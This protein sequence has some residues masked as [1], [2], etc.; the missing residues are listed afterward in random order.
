MQ[1]A[2]EGINSNPQGIKDRIPANFDLQFTISEASLQII[3]D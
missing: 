2:T 1:S 3:T